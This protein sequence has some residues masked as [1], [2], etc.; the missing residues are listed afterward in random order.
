M[1]F[2]QY[3]LHILGSYLYFQCLNQGVT[4]SMASVCCTNALPW[5]EKTWTSSLR[6]VWNLVAL[7]TLFTSS[8]EIFGPIWV[9]LVFSAHVHIWQK[10]WWMQNC[11]F[12]HQTIMNVL[13]EILT[14]LLFKTFR[15]SWLTLHG[16]FMVWLPKERK[17]MLFTLYSHLFWN[18]FLPQNEQLHFA[19]VKILG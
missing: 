17:E 3:L 4:W 8:H 18:F 16:N 11:F 2:F 1:L 9:Q 7:S 19:H 14:L 6:S 10:F 13:L 12:G 15:S 5:H